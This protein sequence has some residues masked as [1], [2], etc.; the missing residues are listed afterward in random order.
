M[1]FDFFDQ[2]SANILFCLDFFHRVYRNELMVSQTES[3]ERVKRER[4]A[5]KANSATAPATVS[6]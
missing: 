5:A 2:A 6:G 4:S 1:I 3:G